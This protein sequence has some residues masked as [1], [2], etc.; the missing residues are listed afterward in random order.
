M[1]R[2]VSGVDLEAELTFYSAYHSDLRNIVIH[3]IFVPALLWTGMVWAAYV[4]LPSTSLKFL[5][6]PVNFAHLLAGAYSIFHVQCDAL[7]GSLATALW[8]MMAVS[9]TWW[10]DATESKSGAK[11]TRAWAPGTCA[12]LAGAIHLLSWYMQLHPGHKIFE[13]RRPALLDAMYQSFSVAPLFVWYE[14]AFALGYRPE[15]AASVHQAVAAQHVAWA[16]A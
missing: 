13:G 9:A 3:A 4:P 6:H 15:L 5:G 10:I 7:L 16:A 1:H 2:L 11:G 14:G 12:K 8:W